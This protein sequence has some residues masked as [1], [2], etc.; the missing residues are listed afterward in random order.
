MVFIFRVSYRCL[1]VFS[2]LFFYLHYPTSF[3]YIFNPIST[4]QYARLVFGNLFEYLIV[5]V[6]LKEFHILI[7]YSLLIF[8]F[9]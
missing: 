7:R 1:S 6:T 8:C 5:N 3:A 9:N 4:T 2:S